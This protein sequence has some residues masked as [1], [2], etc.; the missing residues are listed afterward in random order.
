MA[1][2]CT[3]S[4]GTRR[5]GHALGVSVCGEMAGDPAFTELL[6]AMGYRVQF[7]GANFFPHQPYTQALQQCVSLQARAP[8]F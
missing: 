4:T 6:L 3:R 7:M 5:D 2:P 1:T 8:P